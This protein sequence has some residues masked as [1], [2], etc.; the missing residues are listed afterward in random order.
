M[1]VGIVL[2]LCPRCSASREI[3]GRSHLDGIA[4]YL[5]G[6]AQKRV[7]RLTGKEDGKAQSH[8][9]SRLHQ[10]NAMDAPASRPL[11]AGAP[12]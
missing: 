5:Q 9:Y 7:T 11:T 1:N 10:T 3:R 2:A 12:S 8:E 4:V 6:G